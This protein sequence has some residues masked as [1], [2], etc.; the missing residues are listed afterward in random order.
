MLLSRSSKRCSSDQR[1]TVSLFGA[2]SA[3]TIR[4]RMSAT[5]S[6]GSPRWFGR[7]K[8][9]ITPARRFFDA[10]LLRLM[11][12]D[13]GNALQAARRSNPYDYARERAEA[14]RDRR[15]KR[16]GGWASFYRLRMRGDPRA[17][18]IV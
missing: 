8:S 17:D 13:W 1:L 4:F 5:I 11:E 18:G 2:G 9:P 3:P 15:I 14:E 16:L 6:L 7:T 10:R 12:R